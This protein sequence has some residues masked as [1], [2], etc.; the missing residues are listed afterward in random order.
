MN[1]VADLLGRFGGGE[2]PGDSEPGLRA[3]YFASRNFNNKIE[4]RVDR[5]VNFDYGTNAPLPEKSGTNGF[6]MQ[7]SGSLIAGETGEY[8]FA[9]NTPNGARLW[10]NDDDTPLIDGSVSSGEIGRAHV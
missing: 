2:K 3:N 10:L 9:L 4:T 6:S 8:E 7:W 1:T 5:Q